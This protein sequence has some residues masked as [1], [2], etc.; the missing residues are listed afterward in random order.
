MARVKT[1][2]GFVVLFSDVIIIIITIL[3][4][5]DINKEVNIN[6]LIKINMSKKYILFTTNLT[7]ANP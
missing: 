2:Q 3:F 6:L 4:N 5:V 1:I 7:R